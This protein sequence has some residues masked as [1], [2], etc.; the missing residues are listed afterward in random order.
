MAS[1]S[2]FHEKV[3]LPMAA[4]SEPLGG[5]RRLMQLGGVMLGTCVGDSVAVGFI[6]LTGSGV[7]VVSVNDTVGVEIIPSIC[8]VGILGVQEIST[9]VI[10]KRIAIFIFILFALKKRANGLRYRLLGETR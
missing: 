4:I 3:T 7:F 8:C 2:E 9:T 5:V 10:I 1:G 6:V